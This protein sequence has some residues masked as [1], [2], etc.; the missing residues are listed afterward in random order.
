MYEIVIRS[1][2][3]Y[4]FIVLALRLFGKKELSQLSVIDLVLVLLISNSVQNAMVGNDTSLFGGLIAAS[5]L[6]VMNWVLKNLLFKSEKLSSF[7][8]GN[9]LML[10]YHGKVIQSHIDKA[11]MSHDELE[12][13]VR[14][15]GVHSL[16]DVDLAVLEVDGSISIISNDY[17]HRTTKKRR[18]HKSLTH[19][20]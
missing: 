5:A 9:P 3:V 18:L 4:L 6:F 20:V 15:H 14:E 2:I 11:K 19:S 7:I 12:A 10:I 17:K 13:S 8:Q 1:V 16:D